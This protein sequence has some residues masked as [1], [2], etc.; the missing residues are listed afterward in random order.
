MSDVM[1]KKLN[2]GYFDV[3]YAGDFN[4]LAGQRARKKASH[5]EV[6]ILSQIDSYGAV[7]GNRSFFT[8]KLNCGI[9]TVSRKL[10]KLVDDNLIEIKRLA[11]GKSEY[12]ITR[13]KSKE[14]VDPF[15][16][17][18][19]FFCSHVFEFVYKE[20]KDESGNVVK[21][22][23]TE[24]RRLT[25]AEVMVLALIF[26]HSSKRARAYFWGSASKIADMLALS[27]RQVER[28]IVNLMA[29]GL[30][31]RPVRGKN[32]VRNS[33]YVANMKVLRPL[34]EYYKKVTP[35]ETAPAKAEKTAISPMIEAANA[36]SARDK[37]Y[38]DRRFA[39]E[40]KA[41]KYEKWVSAQSPRY[42]DIVREL[43]AMEYPLANA[44]VY[45]LPTLATLQAKKSTLSA[46]KGALIDRFGIDERKLDPDGWA[47]CSRCRDT[48]FL[49]DGTSCTC[50]HPAKGSVGELKI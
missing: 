12:K 29:A 49:P 33:K 15:Y 27:E 17:V 21:P 14:K 24:K 48:G 7:Q 40:Q 42:F 1:T 38:A 43:K 44:E 36:K 32:R 46:E 23:R 5:N 16:R 34:C 22:A 25:P 3:V 35:V 9:A 41:E 50:Y 13:E 2:T 19:N 4:A 30:I 39:A 45:N 6:F 28:A 26:T 47:R 31:F 20:K 8:E 37:Y 10:K 18:Y 11:N